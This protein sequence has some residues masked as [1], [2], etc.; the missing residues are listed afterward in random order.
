MNHIAI[1]FE[2]LKTQKMTDIKVGKKAKKFGTVLSII[3]NV[4]NLANTFI[5][6]FLDGKE[7]YWPAISGLTMVELCGQ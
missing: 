5:G 6:G 1:L 3:L 7:C 4:I 2:L